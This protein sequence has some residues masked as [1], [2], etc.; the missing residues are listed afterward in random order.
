MGNIFAGSE[1]VEI[2]IQ[3]EINGRDFYGTLAKTLKDK[4]IQDVFKYLAGEEEKHIATFQGILD[5]VHKYEPVEAY[6]GEYFAYMRALASDYVFTQKNKGTEIARKVKNDNE[7]L[8]LSIGLEK[9]SIVFYLE[10]K[11]MVPEHNHKI[12][13]ELISQ[14]QKHLRNLTTLK[15]QQNSDQNIGKSVKLYSTPTCPFCIIVKQFLKDN[16]IKFKDIDV[17]IDQ[18]AAQEMI[19]KS[20][21]MGVPVLD[22]DGK[23][24]VGFDKG[25]IS[26]ALGLS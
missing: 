15:T 9:D 25:A 19:K 12:I 4:K 18:Q 26:K 22:I 3:I 2:G 1:I 24:I 8:D 6:P 13:D 5:S 10:M 17:S 20:G 23:I 7:A 16:R 21:Q 11:K 14:E